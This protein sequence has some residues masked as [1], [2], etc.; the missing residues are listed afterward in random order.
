M[1]QLKKC[2]QMGRNCIQDLTTVTSRSLLAS[3]QK[4]NEVSSFSHSHGWPALNGCFEYAQ[5]LSELA[6]K[7]YVNKSQPPSFQT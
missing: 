6:G 1:K 2:M 4:L 3:H 5:M 7:S